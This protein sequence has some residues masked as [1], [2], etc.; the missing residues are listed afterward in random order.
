MACLPTS[1]DHLQA[2]QVERIP[3]FHKERFK[4]PLPNECCEMIENGHIFFSIIPQ[5]I[6]ACE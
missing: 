4:L 6:L 2:I 5:N 1:P 3:V